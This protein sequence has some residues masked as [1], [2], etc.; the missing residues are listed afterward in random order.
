MNDSDLIAKLED[1]VREAEELLRRRKDALAALKGKSVSSKP[2]ERKKVFRS[3]SIPA[4][5]YETL[6]NGE[7]SLEELTEALK[8]KDPALNNRKISLALSKYVRE[9]KH[10]THSLEGK[11]GIK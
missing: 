8:A 10:F 2:R 1:G 5:A 4:L 3:N 11:Y 9:Q 7:L 6:K